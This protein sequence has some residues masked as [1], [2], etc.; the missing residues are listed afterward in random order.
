M[1]EPTLNFHIQT[2]Q[3]QF[4]VPIELIKK[5]FKNIQK[6]IEKQKKQTSDEISKITK[7]P[8]LPT[9]MK[10]AM[11]K[12]LIKQF[13]SFQHKLKAAVA[14]DEELR[15]RLVARLEN[16]RELDKYCITNNSSAGDREDSNEED[17]EENEKLLD[18]HNPN[19]LNWYRDQTNLLIIDYLIKSNTRTDTNGGVLLLKS[20]SKT[21]PKFMKLID[22]DLFE[23]FNEVFVS[24]VENHDLTLV[25]NWFN[26]NKNFLKKGNSNLEFEINYCKFLSLIEKGD[27]NE[28]IKFSHINLSPYGNKENYQENDNK[29]H[30]A[31]MKRLLGMGGLLVFRSMEN[32]EKKKD[33][34]EPMTF[35][36]NLMINSPQFH[37]YQKLLSDERWESLSRSFIENFTKLYGISKN[38]P[39]FIYL[40]PGLSSLKTKSCYYNNENTIFRDENIPLV[41]HKHIHT[42]SNT[43]HTNG[44]VVIDE[45][46]RGPN[47]YYKLL[48][49]INNCPVCS[50]ELY[51]LSRNLPYAQLITSI[52]NNPFILPNGNIYP[53]DK[54]LNPCEK[55]LSEKNT[56]LRMG[57]VKDPLTKEIFSI[58]TCTRV[59][60]A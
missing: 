46:Y 11:I 58:D 21:N 56:L 2:H 34:S 55:Y 19:L 30:L 15:S 54:L 25:I 39:I 51:K 53:F 24:I 33:S 17:S 5:N 40:S 47:Y 8:N 9:T 59:F 26:E 38:Y 42:N 3:T 45:K 36:S 12:K 37:E 52:F 44:T 50:P 31:N 60:P 7:N 14:R 22:Y 28:A 13:E 23:N 29:N 41:S 48:N 1:T 6:L 57:K 27:I 18:L 35:S 10:L 4:R 32:N 43:V 49:K 20:L 16:L